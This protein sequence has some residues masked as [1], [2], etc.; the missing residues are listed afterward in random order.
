M[1]DQNLKEDEIQL[2]QQDFKTTEKDMQAAGELICGR[3][4]D[5]FVQ[6]GAGRK[7][8]SRTDGALKKPASYKDHYDSDSS[9]QS[10]EVLSATDRLANA[11]AAKLEAET[12]AT[13]PSTTHQSV[14]F[15]YALSSFTDNEQLMRQA[16]IL[17][18]QLLALYVQTLE[19]WGFET[20]SLM[21]GVLASPD[22]LNTKMG[23]KTGHSIR[24]LQFLG[25][26]DRNA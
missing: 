21:L 17:N 3:Q 14:Q 6:K 26:I 4:L 7:K 10:V 8:K 1:G 5:T 22:I 19:D 24:L 25:E 9:T 13:A 16:G 23:F 20:P 11:V 15:K 12:E 2:T 18:E